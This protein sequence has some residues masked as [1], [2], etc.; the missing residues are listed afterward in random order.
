MKEDHVFPSTSHSISEWNS[1]YFFKY[2][3]QKL[4]KN[5]RSPLIKDRHSLS[6]IYAS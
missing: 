2:T 4:K 3:I 1:L 6:N 5:L